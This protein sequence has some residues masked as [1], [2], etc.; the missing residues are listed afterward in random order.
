MRDNSKGRAEAYCFTHGRVA[1]FAN[2]LGSGQEG[3][4]WK[5]T[6]NSAIKVFDRVANFNTELHCYEIL[7]EHN[8][9]E[10]D[11]FTIPILLESDAKLLVI[12]M[13]IVSPPYIL[14]FGKAYVNFP[15]EFSEEVMADYEAEREE[16]FEGNWPLVESVVGS[17]QSYGIFYWDAR[18]GNIN[19]Y[20]HPNAKKQAKSNP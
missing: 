19:C 18:P 5:T 1:D 7:K 15:P 6:A 4:V 12:E 17:L 14:D 3:F 11:G 13:S 20:G 2:L 16:W 9:S 10:I 8:V